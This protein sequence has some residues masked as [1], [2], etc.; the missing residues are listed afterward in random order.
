MY[1]PIGTA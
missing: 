1:I